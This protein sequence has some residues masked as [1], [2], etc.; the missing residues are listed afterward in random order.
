[1]GAQRVAELQALL[2]AYQRESFDGVLP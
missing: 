1:M 2:D